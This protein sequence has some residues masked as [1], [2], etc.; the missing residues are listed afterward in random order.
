MFLQ[1]AKYMKLDQ[2]GHVLAEYIWI[3][4]SNGLRNKTKVR[5]TSSVS[6]HYSRTFA[7]GSNIPSFSRQRRLDIQQTRLCPATRTTTQG[8]TKPRH[9]NASLS[10]KHD[11]CWLCNPPPPKNQSP[12]TRETPRLGRFEPF[13]VPREGCERHRDFPFR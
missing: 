12:S 3:D 1:L 13:E 11:S 5:Y 6:S 8:F 10:R 2:R 7:S 9:A 4:G